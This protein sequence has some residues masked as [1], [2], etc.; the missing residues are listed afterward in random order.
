MNFCH[1]PGFFLVLYFSTTGTWRLG[2]VENARLYADELLRRLQG[3][4][5]F[6]EGRA[7]CAEMKLGRITCGVAF[8]FFCFFHPISI[9]GGNPSNG[10][11]N[12]YKPQQKVDFL[13]PWKIPASK[14]A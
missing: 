6:D 7:T 14:W 1:Q 8:F 9:F 5:S 4:Q 12:I 3:C 2:T 10:Y 11:I 13:R